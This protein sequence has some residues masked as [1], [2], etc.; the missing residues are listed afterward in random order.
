MT[1][2]K[3]LKSAVVRLARSCP[4]YC[5]AAPA[6]FKIISVLVALQEFASVRPTCNGSTKERSSVARSTCKHRRWAHSR[7]LLLRSKRLHEYPSPVLESRV[8]HDF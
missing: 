2:T 1:Q 3:R 5:C 8:R 4:S 7:R 6:P